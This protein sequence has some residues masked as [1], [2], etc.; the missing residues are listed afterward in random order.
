MWLGYEEALKEY[1]DVH[2]EASIKR[3]IKNK[4]ERYYVK[5][6]LHPPW[7][8]DQDF[9]QRHRSV[10]LK[11]EIDRHEKPWYQLIPNFTNDGPCLYYWPYTLS[12]GASATNQGESDASKRYSNKAKILI[13]I[14]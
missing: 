7:T 11:K 12:I 5:N 10:L 9:I 1:L 4:M 2:I 14:K 13:R 8:Y 3:G 6:I